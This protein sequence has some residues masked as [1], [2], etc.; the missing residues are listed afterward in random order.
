[1]DDIIFDIPMQNT[2]HITTYRNVKFSF[3]DDGRVG[4]RFIS[5]IAIQGGNNNVITTTVDYDPNG[6]E[7]RIDISRRSDSVTLRQRIGTSDDIGDELPVRRYNDL[8]PTSIDK[9]ELPEQLSFEG[10]QYQGEHPLAKQVLGYAIDDL[11]EAQSFVNL[12]L[13]G[14]QAEAV[15]Y[16]ALVQELEQAYEAMPGIAFRR[17]DLTRAY[18]KGAGVGNTFFKP[19][20]DPMGAGFW[21]EGHDPL[22][23]LEGDTPFSY[24]DLPSVIG[25]DKLNKE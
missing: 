9:Y 22:S 13:D 4:L 2:G 10:R 3:G 25:P 23:I 17:G 16:T 20:Q 1:M 24:T 8:D 7:G 6:L 14:D 12:E 11:L 18:E 21:R 15:Q 5:T 19:D